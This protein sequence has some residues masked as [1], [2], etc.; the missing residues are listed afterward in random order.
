MDVTKVTGT[1]AIKR[2]FMQ[3]KG[4]P[5]LLQTHRFPLRGHWFPLQ[6][7]CSPY[8]ALIVQVSVTV[9]RV[10]IAQVHGGVSKSIGLGRT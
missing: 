9:P 10:S 1:G 5:F 8:G 6:V 3:S 7:P 4:A 2:G